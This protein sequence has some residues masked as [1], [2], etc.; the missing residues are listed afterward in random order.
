[1][2]LD[3]FEDE[4]GYDEKHRAIFDFAPQPAIEIS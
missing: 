1:M 2:R 4:R 3:R